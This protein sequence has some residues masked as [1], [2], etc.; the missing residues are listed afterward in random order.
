M[1]PAGDGTEQ[2]RTGVGRSMRATDTVFGKS[3][4][5]MNAVL[6]EGVG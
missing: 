4:A 5:R 2:P 3:C 6:P 1:V